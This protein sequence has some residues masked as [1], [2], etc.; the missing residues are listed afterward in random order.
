MPYTVKSSE[1]LRKNGAEGETKALLYLMNFRSDSNQIHYFVVDFFNDLTG[2]DNYSEK[3]WDLQ[4]KYAKNNSPKSVGKE[5]VTLFK[6]YVSDFKFTY[7]ILFLGGVSGTVCIDKNLTSFG[8]DNIKPTA[9]AK[10][11]EGFKEEVLNKTYIDN[12]YLTDDIISDFL[13]EV[14]F[15][16]DNKQPSEYVRAIIKNH[17]AIVTDDN[18]LNAIFNEIRDTQSEKKNVAVEGVTI[19]TVD[20]ALNYYK[21]LTDGEIRLLT[22]QRIINRNPVEKGIPIP[23]LP[24]YNLC[25]PEHQKELTDDCKQAMCRA[26]FNKNAADAFWKLFETVYKL[27][28]SNPNYDVQKIYNEIDVNIKNSCPDFD[29]TSLKY[30]IATIKEG[31]QDD[32]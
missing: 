18:L 14:T 17:T 4:S 7:Y 19:Q 9:M 28:I 21:H 15:V 24:I 5:L 32:N 25:P 6:N 12:K 10:L 1:K 8:I 23:F 29:T 13:K 16:V 22:L 30:F 20:E 31:V 2:M 27:I 26:L 11:I 3:M